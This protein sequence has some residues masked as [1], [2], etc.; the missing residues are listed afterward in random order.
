LDWV[1]I[2]HR[3]AKSFAPGV[4]GD[5]A[6]NISALWD[7]VPDVRVYI[8]AVHRLSNLGAVV[9]QAA[10][11]TS[12][13]GLEAEWRDIN[14]STVEGDLINRC[15]LFD[16][17]D[18][19]AALARFE[20]LS[21]PAP[22]E[23]AASQVATRFRAP[24]ATRDW[25]AMAAILADDFCADDRRRVV[26]SGVRQGRDAEIA[27]IRAT[28]EVGTHH[29]TSTVFAMRGKRLVLVRS[30]F[31]GR[32]RGAE[33]FHVEMLDVVEIN[34]DEQIVARVSF[35]LDDTD[36]AFEELDARYLAGEAAAYEQTWSVISKAYAALNRRELAATT[37]DWVNIDHR[38]G[39]AV[40]RGDLTPYIRAA[41]DVMGHVKEYI[42][43]VH[44]LT[45][46][47]AVVTRVSNGT[48]QEGFDAEWREIDLTTVK[49]DLINRSE[50]FDEADLDTALARFDELNRPARR[51]ENA[52]SRVDEHFGACF[53]ARDWDGTAEM[54]ADDTSTDDRRRTVNSGIRHGRDPV[55]ASMR[56][57]AEV[58]V[59]NGTS[60]VIATRGDRLALSHIRMS[61]HDQGPEAFHIDM[62]GIVEINAD[63]RIAARVTF[64]VDDID[65]AFEEL[66]ARYLAGEAA[67]HAHTWALFTAGYAALNRHEIPATTP[68]WVNIDNRRVARVEAGDLTAYIHA[69]W[70][71]GPHIRA[72]AEAVHRLS[73]LGAVVT[74]TAHG[75]THEGFEAEWREI[76]LATAEGDLINRIE[77]FDQADLDVALARFDELNASAPLENAATRT[78]T[79]LADA[80][81]RRNVGDFVA[82]TRAD[83]HLDDRRKGLRDSHDGSMRRRVV[84]TLFECP[85]SW[86]LE[87]EH[88]AVR[89]SRL[90]LTR[91]TVRDTDQA[92]GPI[93]VEL[94]TVLEVGGDDQAHDSINFDPDDID[95]A[96]EELEARYLAGEAAANA[97]TWSAVM[98]AYASFNRRELPATTP[99]WTNID[100]RRGTAFAPG[101]VVP[102]IRTA[103]D[104]APDI[105]IYIAAVHRLSDV[106]ALVTYAAN[107]TS[108]EGF[109]AEW[110]E[111]TLLAFEGDLISRCEIFDEADLDTAV[112]R[113][114]DLNPA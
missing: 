83:G 26:R 106:G 66:D 4:S 97:Q 75:A 107:G 111:I 46:F 14:V 29:I 112:A 15:E 19:D 77:L 48:S 79:R 85:T 90:C 52:A 57:I 68:D 62:L 24:F 78:W 69:T 49:G 86:R 41:W 11:G 28:V 108:G 44:Q 113:F 7:Q 10:N 55:I 71:L 105:R 13:Q 110:R 59:T 58:G 103:W 67:A 98:G 5:M 35:D 96:F 91:Q 76:V 18:L 72:Y 34:A 45:K 3:R 95:A 43:A 37:P 101:D 40:A 30:R 74:Q 1:N 33:P 6:A 42:E 17:E 102:Y 56:A 104:V 61:G 89:G 84:E 47:G 2:D 8:E 64:D 21:C 87:I 65:A 16:E 114:D 54:L 36:A 94:L 81:N 70:D 32:D 88:V 9:T 31:V 25:D 53:A 12:R 92:D 23:N 51:L 22:L 38:R 20:E 93:T 50:K 73:S 109:D 100:H 27:S 60:A 39:I 82:L 80:F 99:D 63:E